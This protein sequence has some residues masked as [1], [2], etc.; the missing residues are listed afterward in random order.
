MVSGSI[1]H[2][3][4]ALDGMVPAGTRI[5]RLT[6]LFLILALGGRWFVEDGIEGRLHDRNMVGRDILQLN[7]A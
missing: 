7:T 2:H 1:S 4:Q 5:I 3:A 6:T